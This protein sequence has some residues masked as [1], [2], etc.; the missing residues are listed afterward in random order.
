MTEGARLTVYKN[1]FWTVEARAEDKKTHY[2]IRN[3]D[4]V[5]IIP[6]ID[7]TNVLM[8]QHWRHVHERYILEFPGGGIDVGEDPFHAAQRELLEETGNLAERFEHVCTL[9]PA[10][11]LTT[12]VCH[13]FVAE[14]LKRVGVAESEEG[15]V[16]V[17]LSRQLIFD[18]LV[19]NGADA[20][21]LAA[22][23]V[24]FRHRTHS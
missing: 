14:Q 22:W 24:F 12:E 4:A 3:Q 7:T 6:L 13:I 1:E 16:C 15:I 2:S 21:A 19:S 10:P 11:A 9:R 5:L 23:S 8:V 20:M 18:E 17:E